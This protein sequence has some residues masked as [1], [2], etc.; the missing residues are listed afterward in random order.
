MGP[1]NYAFI[2]RSIDECMAED[3]GRLMNYE[4]KVMSKMQE[5]EEEGPVTMTEEEAVETLRQVIVDKQKRMVEE[6]EEVVSEEEQWSFL[7]FMRGFV[8]QKFCL[9]KVTSAQILK[10]NK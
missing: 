2:S 5:E 9:Y 3:I 4:D 8:M 1:D 7:N 6:N 10:L